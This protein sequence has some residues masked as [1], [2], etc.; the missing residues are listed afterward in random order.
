MVKVL[1]E[2][3]FFHFSSKHVRACKGRHAHRDVIGY[4]RQNR[5]RNLRTRT[6]V[7][8]PVTYMLRQHEL[9]DAQRDVLHHAFYDQGC[10]LRSDEFW[11]ANDRA[12]RCKNGEYKRHGGHA[13]RLGSFITASF[14]FGV[15]LPDAIAALDRFARHLGATYGLA[16]EVVIH[17]KDGAPDHAHL[18][19]SDRMV[20]ENGVGAKNRSL[21]GMNAKITGNSIRVDADRIIA[22][23]MEDMRATW[24]TLIRE[25][26]SA[27]AV[28]D[29]R[30]F[31][32]RGLEIKPVRYVPRGAIREQEAQG[33]DLWREDR[34]RELAGRRS[35]LG[36]VPSWRTGNSR[37][38]GWPMLQNIDTGDKPRRRRSRSKHEA[39]L[40]SMAYA[41]RRKIDELRLEPGTQSDTIAEHVSLPGQELTNFTVAGR[42]TLPRTDPPHPN[43][44][45]A[46]EIMSI[47]SLEEL[48]VGPTEL[49]NDMLIS[50]GVETAKPSGAPTVPTALWSRLAQPERIRNP[51][52]QS[53]KE[54][55]IVAMAY[56]A[57]RE[58]DRRRNDSS[59][60]TT[61]R[62]ENATPISARPETAKPSA[63]PTAATALWSRLAQPERIRKPKS[64]SQGEFPIVAMAY[65]ARLKLDGR[66]KDSS[67]STIMADPSKGMTVKA[68]GAR[69]TKA[70]ERSR[71]VLAA[72]S[73]ALDGLRGTTAMA[74]VTRVMRDLADGT[75]KSIQKRRTIDLGPY[76]AAAGR[77]RKQAKS[78][79]DLLLTFALKALALK[80]VVTKVPISDQ[81]PHA[82]E[83]GPGE[84][85][86]ASDL[87]DTGNIESARVAAA[88]ASSIPTGTT[89][90]VSSE[91]S[92]TRSDGN[93]TSAVEVPDV[94]MSENDHVE[95]TPWAV[96]AQQVDPQALPSP[97]HGLSPAG[98]TTPDLQRA[99]PAP[100]VEDARPDM[101]VHEQLKEAMTPDGSEVSKSSKVPPAL[102]PRR[103]AFEI[104][105]KSA[106]SKPAPL[107]FKSLDEGPMVAI[108]AERT[109]NGASAMSAVH[110]DEVNA[111]LVPSPVEAAHPLQDG[112]SLEGTPSGLRKTQD[113]EGKADLSRGDWM[114][115]GRPAPAPSAPKSPHPNRSIASNGISPVTSPPDG[116]RVLDEG[117]PG[118]LLDGRPIRKAPVSSQP[119][120]A[121]APM[122][123][124]D[125]LSETAKAVPGRTASTVS[126]RS[127]EPQSYIS[128]ETNGDEQTFD[129]SAPRNAAESRS[130]SGPG[131]P[132][133]HTSARRA[134]VPN[135]DATGKSSSARSAPRTHND[136]KP[137]DHVKIESE[138]GEETQTADW[139]IEPDKTGEIAKSDARTIGREAPVHTPPPSTTRN[140]LKLPADRLS[141]LLR[142]AA[143]LQNSS[144]I[145]K[146]ILAALA[147]FDSRIDHASIRQAH[148]KCF[149]M[150]GVLYTSHS[151]MTS[152]RL[153]EAMRKIATRSNDIDLLAFF[154]KLD[155]LVRQA[156]RDSQAKKFGLIIVKDASGVDP[157]D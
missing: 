55:S 127:T 31:R 49:G 147:S 150:P 22:A 79:H 112:N 25:I 24:A 116:G 7:K 132:Q 87:D 18:L 71:R 37:S 134:A 23:P 105:G 67:T 154:D 136:A 118:V 137:S 64:R 15:S 146:P 140:P 17:A 80:R 106:R 123:Q 125:I 128:A 142:Y 114:P 135:I 56:A 141:L 83:S 9:A 77:R 63:L 19:V 100:V 89:V 108:G 27:G 53:K 10:G 81:N 16:C 126:K 54:L 26:A 121:S 88:D 28:I 21:N 131:E 145:S 143:A 69:P 111:T 46:G 139:K 149:E 42:W 115:S 30:S 113:V 75:K 62:D 74:L 78:E 58:V 153:R 157:T 90:G 92:V 138:G 96:F 73:L 45:D 4:M 76:R 48:P 65:A 117:S 107:I 103:T 156:R 130:L 109:S 6:R 1:E 102:D 57:R 5:E 52:S 152:P 129:K 133:D 70:S 98:V 72:I 11:L 36:D 60:S 50:A 93:G 40:A 68:G 13:P 41:A 32:R 144:Q 148:I 33:L 29:H 94:E 110:Q 122:P 155:D 101:T 35:V 119:P 2:P 39:A 59:T 51:K 99:S 95:L 12:N 84:K 20:D 34:S 43:L 14:P 47:G 91:A 120:N 104:G 97:A 86:W 61:I 66:R 8:D 85:V 3:G 38:A 151:P 124:A 44:E 82:G